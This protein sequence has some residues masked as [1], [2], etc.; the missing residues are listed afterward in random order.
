M[1]RAGDQI[2]P[3][4]LISKIGRGN[5]GVVWLA[6][7]RTTI[8]TTR[9]ALKMP[10]DD[11]VDLETI[12][13]EADLWVQAS[14]HPNVLPIIEANIYDDQVVIASEYAPDGS[15]DAWLRKHGGA[16]PSEDVAV[17]MTSGIL[18]GLQHLHS[19]SI[20]HRDLKPQNLLLQGETPRLADFG[21]SRVLKS[22]SQ[23]SIV[24]GTPVYMAPEAF[25]GKRN[26]QTDVWSAGVILYQLLS[27]HLPFPQADITSLMGAILT[28]NPDPLPL[29]IPDPLQEVITRS[30]KKDTAQR[31]KS[32]TEMRAALRNAMEMIQE[33]KSAERVKQQGYAPT[34]K[35]T[36]PLRAAT[37]TSNISGS[38][39]SSYSVKPFNTGPPSSVNTMSPALS[40]RQRVR[41][42][43]SPRFVY[44]FAIVVGLL[45]AAV[46]VA[47]LLKSGKDES[48]SES[49]LNKQTGTKTEPVKK[50]YNVALNKPVSITTNGANDQCAGCGNKPSDVTDGSLSYLP[51]SGDAPDDGCVGFVNNDYRQLMIIN[52]SINLQQTYHITKIRYNPGDVEHET[53]NADLMVT[54]FGSTPTN[55]GSTYSG[56]WTELTGSLIASTITIAL[57]KTRKSD[58]TDWLFIGEVEIMGFDVPQA[59]STTEAN[60]PRPSGSQLE[61]NSTA[62]MSSPSCVVSYASGC[63]W[64]ITPPTKPPC[65]GL[66]IVKPA[67]TISPDGL[68]CTLT[69]SANAAEG[70]RAIDS[71]GR[72]FSLHQGEQFEV[73]TTGLVAFSREHPCSGPEGMF[74]W[75]DP[76]VDSP[77]KQNVGG[78]EFSIGPLNSSRLFAGKYYYGMAEHNGTRVFRIIERKTGYH[79]DNSGSFT[80]T[81]EKIR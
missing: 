18:A 45:I 11:D 69:V 29:S 50:E 72:R 19:R 57:Q 52:V 7:R 79:D 51:V 75:Y 30:L 8:T 59:Q 26:E 37:P 68:I 54:P 24:A 16:A 1:F 15:L 53:W 66:P 58:E 43:R 77:F 49:Q 38:Q 80:V 81:V 25:D 34:V 62:A 40:P 36:D 21:I 22:T 46:A 78:L 9:V 76:Y 63:C 6:E 39:P 13:Q 73:R 14:G 17:E 31:Y 74:G 5:F 32:A 35:A 23:S 60:P 28:R 3:Y 2:G 4:L 67:V 12:R 55:H 47:V 48:S 41:K 61:V 27:G 33:S 70:L 65:S 64:T 44:T 71:K 42:G 10:L 20:I 56:T